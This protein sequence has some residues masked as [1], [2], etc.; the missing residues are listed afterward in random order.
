MRI[1]KSSC[2]EHNDADWRV[3]SRTVEVPMADGPIAYFITWTTYGTRLQGDERGW[4]KRRSSLQRDSQPQLK[5][6]HSQ[7]LLYPVWKLTSPER[8]L[9]EAEVRRVCDWRDWTLWACS[10]RTNHVHCTI[11]AMGIAGGKVREQLK[12]NCTRVLREHSVC[13]RN[14]P[15]WSRN[16]DVQFIDDEEALERRIDYILIAQDRKYAAHGY[17]Y[18]NRNDT[19]RNCT[20]ASRAH[21]RAVGAAA[22]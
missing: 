14:R 12:A 11:T 21:W 6:W 9:V 8:K 10:A 2:L 15:V 1:D 17:G 20:E 7:R 5:A 19:S 16:G 4:R 3:F 13:Y 22:P 18:D